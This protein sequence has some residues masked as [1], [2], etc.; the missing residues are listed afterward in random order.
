MSR[1]KNIARARKVLDNNLARV[2]RS[3]AP[4]PVGWVR[5]I[6]EAVGMTRG[7]LGAR[8]F[9]AR[10]ARCGISASAVQALERQEQRGT[11][12]LDSLR[13]AAEAMDCTLFYAIVPHDSLEETVQT[14][15]HFIARRIDD[16]T[17]RTMQLEAQNYDS[18]LVGSTASDLI[19]SRAL[20]R[21]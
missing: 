20:W 1:A 10:N 6:R 2:D 7:Q 12:T 16:A 19:N 15:A 4:P 11:V 5:A 9:S 13:R 8:M 3:V 14:Q 21:E 18:A 17:R